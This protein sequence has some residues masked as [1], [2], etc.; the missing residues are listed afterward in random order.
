MVTLRERAVFSG[1][2]GYG[3]SIWTPLVMSLNMRSKV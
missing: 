1:D 2:S 3:I